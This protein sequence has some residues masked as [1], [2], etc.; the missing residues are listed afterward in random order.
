M[1]NPVNSA[2]S[3]VK[4]NVDTKVMWSTVAGIAVF[5]G[6]VFLAGKSGFGPL[7]QAAQIAKGAK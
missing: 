2:T 4:N 1:N 6:L 5:G 7:K 3:A